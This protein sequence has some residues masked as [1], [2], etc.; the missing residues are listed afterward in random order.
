VELSDISELHYITH[1]DNLPSIV[2]YG[3]LCHREAQLH[4][5]ISVADTH[6][7]ARR[8]GKQVPQGLMLHD[9]ANLYINARNPKMY[10]VTYAGQ[11]VEK[12][13]VVS[14][15]K[16]ILGLQDVVIADGNA[17]SGYTGF[18]PSPSGLEKLDKTLVFADSWKDDDQIREWKKKSA[19]CAEVLVPSTVETKY[20]ISIL[21]ATEGIAEKV[22][23]RG[24]NLPV[25]SIPRLFFRE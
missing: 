13:C 14:I 25:Q 3:I 17:A 22:H 4:S 7:Q 19:I 21:V 8:K 24:I 12:I 2:R 9:Y 18:W 6:I 20:I 5:P 1:T 15:S 10:K 23:A 11:I 16:D